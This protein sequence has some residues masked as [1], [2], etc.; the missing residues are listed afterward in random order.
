MSRYTLHSLVWQDI[1]E[2]WEFIASDNPGAANRVEDELFAAFE[3]LA[4]NPGLGHVRPDLNSRGLLFWV[5]RNYLIAYETSSDPLAIVMVIH[6][7][8]QPAKMAETLAR[9]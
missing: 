4:Q 5:V 3:L 7:A 8:R 2:I 1:S 9:R 6:G